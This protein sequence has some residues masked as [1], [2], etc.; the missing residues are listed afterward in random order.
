MK[1]LFIILFILFLSSTLFPQRLILEVDSSQDLVELWKRYLEICHN[2]SFIVWGVSFF[3]W[4][5]EKTDTAIVELDDLQ[6]LEPKAYFSFYEHRKPSF[7]EFTRFVKWTKINDQ[8][9][10]RRK[11]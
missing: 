8:K 5:T 11:D 7:R 4:Q 9:A 1:I 3:N 6:F 10:I 2:D